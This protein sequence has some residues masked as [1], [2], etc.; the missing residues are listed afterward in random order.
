MK[1]KKIAK[2]IKK[3]LKNKTI[4]VFSDVDKDF[5]NRRR[6]EISGSKKI[7]DKLDSVLFEGYT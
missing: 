2:I 7:M 1:D 3:L 4:I 6:V 5:P